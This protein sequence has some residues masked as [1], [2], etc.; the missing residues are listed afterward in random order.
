MA[1]QIPDIVHEPDTVRG[2]SHKPRGSMYGPVANY[3]G[4]PVQTSTPKKAFYVHQFVL[5]KDGNKGYKAGHIIGVGIEGED[6]L[7]SVK[8][9]EAHGNIVISTRDVVASPH[10]IQGSN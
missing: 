1:K 2:S 8:L 10:E 9:S 3:W 6:R 4:T 7:Y 5:A